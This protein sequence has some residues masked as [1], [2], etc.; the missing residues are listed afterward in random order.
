MLVGQ[1]H[2]ASNFTVHRHNTGYCNEFYRPKCISN[3]FLI[4]NLKS[5]KLQLTDRVQW[6]DCNQIIIAGLESIQ[7]NA[8]KWIKEVTLSIFNL[9]AIA[10]N[11][12]FKLSEKKQ[13]FVAGCG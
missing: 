5:N 12:S 1:I 3:S 7:T 13:K 8:L 6:F 2:T 10:L 4:E 9:I 11:Q